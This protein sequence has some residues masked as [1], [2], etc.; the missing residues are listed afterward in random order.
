MAL[1]IDQQISVRNRIEDCLQKAV[2]DLTKA[3]KPDSV[4][5]MEIEG[6]IR[7]YLEQINSILGTRTL[8]YARTMKDVNA[9]LEVW[10]DALKTL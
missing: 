9:Q 10:E 5:R 6:K 7:T 3:G 1:S 8:D 2:N 4:Y